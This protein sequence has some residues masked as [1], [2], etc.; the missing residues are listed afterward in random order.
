[1]AFG[2][3]PKHEVEIQ[4]N[5]FN[6][7]RYIAIALIAAEQLKWNVNY[8][9]NNGLIA[10]TRKSLFTWNS[11]FKFTVKDDTAVISSES[12]GSEIF[13]WGKNKKKVEAF[14]DTYDQLQSSITEE[15]IEQKLAE[16]ADIIV[17]D[18]E[19]ILIAPPKTSGEKLKGVLSLF[20]PKGNYFITPILINL[21]ILIFILMTITGINIIEPDTQSLLKWGANFKPLTLGGEWW[22]LLTST[23]IHIGIIHLLL[24][25]YALLYIGML[26]ERYLG[27]LRFAI[28]YLITGIFASLTSLW[29]HNFTVSAGASGA[30]FGLYGVFL[31][32][33]TTNFIDK[34]VR[35]EMLSSIGIFVFYNLVYGIKAGIDN[36]AHIGGLL[37]GILVGYSLY[38]SIINNTNLKL[39]HLILSGLIIITLGVSAVIINKMPNTT[40]SYDAMM[41]Q[42]TQNE[43]IAIDVLNTA[44]GKSDQQIADGLKEQGLTNWNKN[45]ALLKETKKLD[46][47]DVLKERIDI[48]T[49]Y[50]ELRVKAYTFMIKS[51]EEKTL[52]YDPIIDS[53]N[54]AI[55]QIITESQNQQ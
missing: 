19:D 53:C 34:N 16:V 30:I 27:K 18:S 14:L 22:R 26:L 44:K 48:L 23:F 47:P 33:L 39:K 12:T 13:D 50:C 55:N 46:L 7:R 38:P 21:N 40:V 6:Q 15:Q 28:A 36:A 51:L 32:M 42:F 37:S 9:S 25:M 3:S 45:L 24:N 43:K 31:A 17:A 2:F 4:L 20:I 54:T 35:K 1:M 52:D 49:R 8:L 41:A 11:E 29:W 5:G 10:Y